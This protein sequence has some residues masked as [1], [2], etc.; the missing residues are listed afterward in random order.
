[1]PG[2]CQRKGERGRK[3]KTENGEGQGQGKGKGKGQ[4]TGKRKGSLDD[5]KRKYFAKAIPETNY[6]LETSHV[7][8]RDVL[9]YKKA[10]WTQGKV[11]SANH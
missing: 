4:V 8:V 11:F 5:F 6:G 10:K 1:M 2:P 9:R 3:R 7:K